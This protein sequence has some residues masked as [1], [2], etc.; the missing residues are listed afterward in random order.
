MIRLMFVSH[1]KRWIDLSLRNLTGDWF[2]RI[3]E[4]FAG[5]NGSAA[6]PS[7]LQSYT[8]LNNP[9]PF[10]ET[11]FKSYPLTTHQLLASEDTAYFLAIAQRPGQKLV[12]FIPVLDASF[13]VWFKKVFHLCLGYYHIYL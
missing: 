5:V 8:S 3:E 13:E 1:E 12:P 11:F 9:L 7:N 4:C 6:K 2:H 10:V